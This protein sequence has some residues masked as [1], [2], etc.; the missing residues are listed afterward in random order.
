MR[1]K[2]G[3][4]VYNLQTRERALPHR[5]GLPQLQCAPFSEAESSHRVVVVLQTGVSKSAQQ[6]KYFKASG[7]AAL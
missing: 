3:R 4:S 7:Y 6:I 2:L 5:S 1:S